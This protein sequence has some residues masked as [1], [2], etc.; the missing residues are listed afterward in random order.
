MKKPGI[1][2]VIIAVDE[3]QLDR[4][5]HAVHTQDRPF[6]R[7]RLVNNV[8]PVATAYNRAMADIEYERVMLVGGDM[9]L[10]P[11]AARYALNLT[12][13]AA[14]VYAWGFGLWD[15]FIRKVICCTK[16]YPG[17]VAGQYPY[18]DVLR[19][20]LAALAE[21]KKDGLREML[22]LDVVLGTHFENPNADQVF[23]RFYVRGQK[24]RT[25]LYRKLLRRMKKETGDRRYDVALDALAQGEAGPRLG[26][27]PNIERMRE[28]AAGGK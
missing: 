14:G 2:C 22:L 26:C 19:C 20:D 8:A 7:V 18:R 24:P 27:S 13:D 16:V 17:D 11:H 10:Y 1:E 9:I 25:G 12:M 21:A 23:R 5:L 28:V 15:P 3:P 6:D 4:C